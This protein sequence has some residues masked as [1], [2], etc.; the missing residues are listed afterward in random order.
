MWILI[1]LLLCSN[2]YAGQVQI[3]TGFGYVTD[4]NGHIVQKIEHVPGTITIPDT[5]I[6]TEVASDADLYA[7]TVY[8]TPVSATDAFNLNIFLRQLAST[9]LITD[10]NV[11]PYYGVMRDLISFKNF[12][13]LANLV[14]GLLQAGLIN[15]TEVDTLD[16]TLENQAINLDSYN[17]EVNVA[18]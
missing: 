11:L 6:Y 17:A 4:N 13:Q 5:S 16:S 9:S 14:G 1:F 2:A 10:I 18:Y 7:I 8:I 3:N 15:Q 12:Q